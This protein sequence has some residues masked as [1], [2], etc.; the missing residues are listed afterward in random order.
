MAKM[1]WTKEDITQKLI[2]D[3]CRH[4]NRREVFLKNDNQVDADWEMAV[5]DYIFD[6]LK[7]ITGEPPSIVADMIDEYLE[8]IFTFNP[9]ETAYPELKIGATY[10]LCSD[11]LYSDYPSFVSMFG[12]DDEAQDGINEYFEI[13]DDEVWIPKGTY[14]IYK[15]CEKDCSGWPTFEIHGEEFDFAGDPFKL[16]L[17][18]EK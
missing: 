3:Y 8:G 16:K 17:V 7:D 2:N 14:M 10:C 13:R 1:M 12:D 9:A 18:K 5:L 4:W 15:G 6:T 11:V